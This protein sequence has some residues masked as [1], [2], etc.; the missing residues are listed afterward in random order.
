MN[1]VQSS[2]VIAFGLVSLFAFIK[3]CYQVF[4]KGNP[5]GEPFI[6]FWL[7]IFVWGDAVVLGFFWTSVSVTCLLVQNWIMFWLT[8]SVFW[9]VRSL[10]E[11]IYWINQ[12]FSTI[13]RNPPQT[14]IGYHWFKNDSI[15]F[16]YQIIWQCILVIAIIATILLVI[17]LF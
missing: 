16:V 15:W 17:E 4:K 9:I 12:Q 11:V 13:V 8:V 6:L 10:G 5:F 7:G 3:G 14:L 2:I 1:I